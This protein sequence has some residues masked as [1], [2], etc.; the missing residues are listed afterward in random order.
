MK[1]AVLCVTRRNLNIQDGTHIIPMDVSAIPDD[2]FHFVNRTVVDDLDSLVMGYRLPQLL[3]YVIVKC[4]DHVLSYA[5]KGGEKRLHGMRSLG[6]GGHVDIDD[7]SMLNN[8]PFL[9]ALITSIEREV[10]EE[11]RYPA[12]I[13]SRQLDSIIVDTSNDVG[14]VH[15]GVPVILDV[16]Y[17]DEVVPNPDELLDPQW[18]HVNDLVAHRESYE[19]WSKLLIDLLNA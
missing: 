10:W 19:N 12:R 6:I 17:R 5:R 9:S 2:Q 11:I 18:I 8:K 16:T 4:G 15:L 7:L 13:G 1:K 3:G 14:K